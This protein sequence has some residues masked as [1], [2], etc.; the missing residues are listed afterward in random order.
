MLC[1]A[2]G[3][4]LIPGGRVCPGC[5]RLTNDEAQ[6]PIPSAAGVGFVLAVGVLG[7]LIDGT[8]GAFVGT[9]FG[10]IALALVSWG[11]IEP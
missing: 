1:P 5:E 11:P 3:A 10:A 2:C 6:Q 9:G 7:F 8:Q 4:R